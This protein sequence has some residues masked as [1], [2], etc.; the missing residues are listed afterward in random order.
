[1]VVNASNRAKIRDW[2]LGHQGD[3]DIGFQDRTLDTGMI[4][5]QGPKALELVGQF[6]P[7]HLPSLKYYTGV[8]TQVFGAPTLI[9][10]TGYT[11]EDGCEIIASASDTRVIWSQLCRSGEPL[12]LRPAGLGARDTLRLEAGMPLY[13]HELTEEI[14]PAQTGLGFAIHLKERRFVGRDAILAAQAKPH[15]PQRVGLEMSGKRAAR[16]GCEIFDG[17]RQIGVVTSGTFS[18]TLQRP[19]SMGYVLPEFAVPG[20]TVSIDNRGNRHEAQIAALPFYRRST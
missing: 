2:I 8:R 6:T 20:R 9:S 11:G 12:G 14:N 13:G 7:I 19:I 4:A 3:H 16:E 5:L 1:M 17:K 15:L 10:R 18:P